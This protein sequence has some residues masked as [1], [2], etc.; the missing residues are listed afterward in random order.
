MTEPASKYEELRSLS[1]GFA[2]SRVKYTDE[3]R[4]ERRRASRRLAAEARR[5]ALTV[6]ADVHRDEYW[7]LYDQER[8][9][10]L[11]DDRYKV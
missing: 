5:R 6:L 11:K 9:V 2:T 1:E 3:E 4:A 7:A 10:L 8:T